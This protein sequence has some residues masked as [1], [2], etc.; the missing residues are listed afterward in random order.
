MVITTKAQGAE[1]GQRFTLSIPTQRALQVALSLRNVLGAEAKQNI[2]VSEAVF[3]G[4][5]RS[6]SNRKN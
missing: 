4:T 1:L 6:L 3:D 5:V 2:L